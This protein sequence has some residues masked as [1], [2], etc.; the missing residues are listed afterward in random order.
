MSLVYLFIFFT[1]WKI[2]TQIPAA[3]KKNLNISAA[4]VQV[5]NESL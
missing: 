3:P 1:P 4:T 5:G 2:V